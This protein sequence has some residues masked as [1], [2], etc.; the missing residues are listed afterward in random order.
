[1]DTVQPT[2]AQTIA[3]LNQDQLT[4]L[5]D[6]RDANLEAKVDAILACLA[7]LPK[8]LSPT[9]PKPPSPLLNVKDLLRLTSLS[10]P[11]LLK[12]LNTGDLVASKIGGQ[13]R[14]EVEE[15]HRWMIRARTTK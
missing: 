11:T 14:V 5:L 1:M 2:P 8:P 13:W 3:V 12:S 7:A 4:L 10:E 15:Y 6:R 9:T